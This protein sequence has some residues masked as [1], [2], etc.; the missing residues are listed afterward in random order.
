MEGRPPFACAYLMGHQPSVSIFTTTDAVSTRLRHTLRLRATSE[1]S[2]CA[3]AWSRSAAL[4]KS[5]AV[6]ETERRSPLTCRSD[7]QRPASRRVNQRLIS[8]FQNFCLNSWTLST[9]RRF[10]PSSSV[11]FYHQRSYREACHGGFVL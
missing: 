11:I 3:S 5:S 2:G 7:A 6:L 8:R 9:G 10:P 1:S 4:S